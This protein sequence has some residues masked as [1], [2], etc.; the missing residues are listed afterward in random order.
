LD[1]AGDKIA[2]PLKIKSLP[3]LIVVSRDGVIR[4]AV[5]GHPKPQELTALLQKV[6]GQISEKTK[7][8]QNKN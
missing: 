1:E 3:Y 2:T 8:S 4:E 5:A 6:R 7:P